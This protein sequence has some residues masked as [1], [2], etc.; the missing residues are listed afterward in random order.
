MKE[1]T[2]RNISI[3]MCLYRNFKGCCYGYFWNFEANMC[4]S[5]LWILS[6]YLYYYHRLDIFRQL[7]ALNICVRTLNLISDD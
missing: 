3:C 4:E 6:K 2:S 7:I 1:M 5:K